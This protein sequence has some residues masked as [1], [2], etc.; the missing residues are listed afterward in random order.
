[1]LDVTTTEQLN[2]PVAVTVAPQ[3]VIEAPDPMLEVIVAAGVNPV[4]EIV[5]ETP[6]GPRA[7]VSEIAGCV[8]VNVAVALSKLPSEPVAVTV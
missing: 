2:V 3:D 6:L 5:V 7:G 1:M 4:P 8:T